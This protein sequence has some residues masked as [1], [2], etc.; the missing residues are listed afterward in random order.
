MEGD[1]RSMCDYETLSFCYAR[2]CN[3]S[4]IQMGPCGLQLVSAL[5]RA[6]PQLEDWEAGGGLITR[7]WNHLKAPLTFTSS[8]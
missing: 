5:C 2:G 7:L 4:G 8:S 3:G 6:G 1:F